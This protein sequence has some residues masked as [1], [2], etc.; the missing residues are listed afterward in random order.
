[1]DRIHSC[2]LPVAC[3]ETYVE[4]TNNEQF[5][6]TRQHAQSRRELQRLK[7]T[8]SCNFPTDNCELFQTADIRVFRSSNFPKMVASRPTFGTGT[9]G[10]KLSDRLQ[11]RERAVAR[12]VP[13]R[14]SWRQ[15]RSTITG[16]NTTPWRKVAL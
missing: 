9:F 2:L 12:A 14:L 7:R 10:S 16:G 3:I 8:G 4:R 11:F 1:M 5:S 6:T 15:S 13:G